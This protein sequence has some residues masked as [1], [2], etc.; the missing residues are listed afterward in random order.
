[1]Y[2][3]PNA[4]ADAAANVYADVCVDVNSCQLSVCLTPRQPLFA[5]EFYFY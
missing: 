3:K 5:F 2:G 1:M 4:D